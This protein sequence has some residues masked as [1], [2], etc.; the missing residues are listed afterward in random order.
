MLYEVITG[1]IR[2]HSL[3]PTLQTAAA[4]NT[5]LTGGMMFLVEKLEKQLIIEALT[6]NN[7]NASKAAAELR[8]TERILGLRIKKYNI[9]LWRFKTGEGS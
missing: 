9:D 8:I 2:S 7:G 6:A 3:P 4:S 1:V 5:G